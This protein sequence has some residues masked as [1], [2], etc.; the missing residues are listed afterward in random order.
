MLEKIRSKFILK[1]IFGQLLKRIKL[2]ILKY[3][4]NLLSKLNLGKKDF[5]DFIY[6]KRI[7]KKFG[8]KIKE[9]EI[10]KIDLSDKNSGFHV[11]EELKKI[12]FRNLK[13]LNLSNNE[14]LDIKDLRKLKFEK[15]EILNLSSKKNIRY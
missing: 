8:I 14:L 6:L 15:L 7:R 2:N 4:K 10:E 12:E 11:F 5:E 13:E 3:N 9:I 1:L